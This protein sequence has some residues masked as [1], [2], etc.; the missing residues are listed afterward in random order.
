MVRR[1]RTSS[2]R[3]L[4]RKDR[5]EVLVPIA[6]VT[7]TAEDDSCQVELNCGLSNALIFGAGALP[8]L[9]NLGRR[10]SFVAEEVLDW[11]NARE[12]YAWDDV[13]A[14]LNRLLANGVIVRAEDARPQASP[15]EG[16]WLIAAEESRVPVPV[17]VAPLLDFFRTAARPERVV[18]DLAT[19]E[20]E[21]KHL[22]ALLKRLVELGF[23]VEADPLGAPRLRN[24]VPRVGRVCLQNPAC[25]Q[26]FIIFSGGETL[27][28]DQ[29]SSAQSFLEAAGL[30]DRNVILLR[31]SSVSFYTQGVSADCASAVELLAW[32]R[33]YLHALPAVDEVYCVGSSQGAYAALIYGRYL[34]ATTVWTFGLPLLV[35][36][37]ELANNASMHLGPEHLARLTKS[38]PPGPFDWNALRVLSEVQGLTE[39]RILFAS[40]NRNDRAVAE[41]MR[42]LP[43]VV[44]QPQPGGDHRLIVSMLKKPDSLRS[45][46]PAFR[47]IRHGVRNQAPASVEADILAYVE[48]LLGP[49]RS[50][51]LTTRSRLWEFLDSI[52]SAELLVFVQ[53]RFGVHISPVEFFRGELA[54]VS[55]IAGRV[56]GHEEGAPGE[57]S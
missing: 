39:Y 37:D 27:A 11:A 1:T 28:T 44:L 17:S 8:F 36:P 54:T 31:D 30:V 13:Q 19:T 18:G 25:R 10:G 53:D 35:F 20:A 49:A 26:V 57:K 55:A 46:F 24:S 29:N 21:A 47:G 45:L 51:A 40:E 12:G 5:F 4:M 14:A 16:A 23:L 41:R 3:V 15:T 34:N 32:L 9:E 33:G 6:F 56:S 7:T 43:R 38:P 2:S 48:K 52:E 22:T 50:A 42:G